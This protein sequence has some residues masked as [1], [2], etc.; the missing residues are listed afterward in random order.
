MR[1]PAGSGSSL[2]THAADVPSP[3]E[4]SAS[5]ASCTRAATM[6]SPNALKTV[7]S[8]RPSSV[9]RATVA[10]A[11]ATPRSPSPSISTFSGT[12]G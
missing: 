12:S 7:A 9:S 11:V 6:S 3:G 4:I 10:V 1:W 2:N 8:M 5:G